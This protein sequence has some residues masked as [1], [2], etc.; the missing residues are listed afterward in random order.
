VI[1]ELPPSSGGGSLLNLLMTGVEMTGGPLATMISGEG[2]AELQ[3]ERGGPPGIMLGRQ[4]AIHVGDHGAGTYQLD[5]LRGPVRLAS[6]LDH[7][8]GLVQPICVVSAMERA[9]SECS[10]RERARQLVPG[11]LR[12]D[13]RSE[14]FDDREP[15]VMGQVAC[16]ICADPERVGTRVVGVIIERSR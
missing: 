13:T 5:Q 16:A 8:E 3:Y 11:N 14:T 9:R 1:R 2:Q 12:T 7:G 10:D 4:L 15:R 6:P